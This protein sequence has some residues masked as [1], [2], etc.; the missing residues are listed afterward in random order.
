MST[1]VMAACWPLQLPPTPKAVLI[2]LAD[3]ANDHGVCWPSLSTIC[4]RTCFGRTA[5]IEAVRYLEDN[6]FLLADRSNGRHTKYQVVP[7]LDLF[8][9]PKAVRQ[10]DQSGRRTG[11]GG[12]RPPSASRTGPVREADTNRKEPS[13][14]K[15]NSDSKRG[16]RLPE[17]WVPSE[18]LKAWAKHEHPTVDVAKA[19]KGF[20]D[21]WIGVS[22]SRGLKLDWDATFRN[23]I[24]DLDEGSSQS[25][26]PPA[27]PRAGSSP[28]VPVTAQSRYDDAVRYARQM[29]DYGSI[30]QAKHDRLVAEAGE[31]LARA[32]PRPV[33]HRAEPTHP[34]HASEAAIR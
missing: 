28:A 15:S 16:S 5:V 31:R 9:L 11:S 13:K 6:G 2:S 19:A 33:V 23:R 22:G 21:Y 26:T 25:S 3:N 17:G 29:L 27:A 34:T 18:E 10:P 20:V 1:T 4:Q 12:E 30:D 14:E 32:G 7:R 24:R 8:E